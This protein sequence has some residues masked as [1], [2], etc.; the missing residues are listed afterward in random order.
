VTATEA[1]ALIGCSPAQVRVLI[2]TGKI[3]AIKRKMPGG[4]YYVVSVA[5]AKR[6]RDTPQKHGGWPRGQS[7]EYE[8]P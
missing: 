2:R 5:E 7:W 4:Y 8:K 1:A 6:Y 3:K